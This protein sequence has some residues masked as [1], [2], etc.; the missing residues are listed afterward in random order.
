MNFALR[1]NKLLENIMGQKENKVPIVGSLGRS[2]CRVN[3]HVLILENI[4]FPHRPSSLW[5]P[6]DEWTNWPAPWEEMG[7]LWSTVYSLIKE[8]SYVY[9]HL[10]WRHIF[11]SS[12][13]AMCIHGDKAQAER[14][15][16]LSGEWHARFKGKGLG[17]SVVCLFSSSEF[18]AGK[19]PILIATDV[20]SRG[21]G[22]VCGAVKVEVSDQNWCNHGRRP[23]SP[24]E[25]QYCE[26]GVKG[27]G[28]RNVQL[29]KIKAIGKH[30][31][32]S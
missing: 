5:R 3:R 25:G 6:N 30:Q 12:W 23:A 22:T 11:L 18:R 16:V 7:E 10:I 4:I 14:D 31:P 32:V 27:I 13:P 28:C 26:C 2:Y 21:L 8:H 17:F 9:L 1:L 19:S 29:Q 15:W 20:A 24:F